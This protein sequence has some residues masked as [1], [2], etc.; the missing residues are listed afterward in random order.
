LRSQVQ[1][2]EYSS[3]M[4]TYIFIYILTI[5]LTYILKIDVSVFLI[6][7]ILYTEMLTLSSVFCKENEKKYLTNPD[8]LSIMVIF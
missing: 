2:L 4:L 1:Y 7:Y 5:Y 8:L 6:F 3:S